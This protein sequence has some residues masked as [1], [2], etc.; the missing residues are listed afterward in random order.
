MANIWRK[1]KINVSDTFLNDFYVI[2]TIVLIY[3]NDTS[4]YSIQI[5]ILPCKEHKAFTRKP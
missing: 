4:D 1:E 5:G 2:Y 3:Q